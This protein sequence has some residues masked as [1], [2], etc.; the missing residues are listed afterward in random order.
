MTYTGFRIGS[1]PSVK[2]FLNGSNLK[3]DIF[4]TRI[5]AGAVTGGLGA[6]IFAPI[7]VVRVRMQADSGTLNRNSGILRTG[8]RQGL[9]PR[10]RSTF[11]AFAKIAKE[12]DQF[13]K[14]LWRGSSTTVIRA[15][16]FSAVQ[17]SCY[18]TA[19]RALKRYELMEEGPIMHASCSLLSGILGQTF[20][21]PV[22]TARSVIMG[23]GKHGFKI[24]FDEFYRYQ[25]RYLF[26]G[27]VP[28]ILRQGPLIFI[29]MPIIE[30]FRKIAGIGYLE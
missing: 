2:Q 26:R 16:I 21:Q 17:L 10:Y 12:E 25:F 14:A 13:L 19:K 24:F 20:I 6:L 1:Y 7:D 9:R 30:Q 22:D 28:A 5:C 11:H 23:N 29:Q 4:L 3:D 15:A 18:D 8:I 27:Y